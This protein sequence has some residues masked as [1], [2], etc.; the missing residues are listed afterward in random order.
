[1]PT[2]RI[3]PAELAITA[4]FFSIYAGARGAA[5]AIGLLQLLVP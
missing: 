2:P 1:M 5:R 3:D 4:A